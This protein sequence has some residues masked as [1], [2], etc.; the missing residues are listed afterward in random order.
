MFLAALIAASSVTLNLPNDARVRGTEL[1]LAAV[2]QVTSDDPELVERARNYALG[3]APAPGYSRLLMAEHLERELE[4]FLGVDVVVKGQP[5]CRVYP[6]IERVP[7]ATIEAAARRELE[8]TLL[9]KDAKATLL[10]SAAGIDV[11]AGEAPATFLARVNADSLRSG[12]FSVP[13]EVRVDGNAYRTVWTNWRLDLWEQ[14]SVLV[15]P[16][17]AGELITSDMLAEKRVAL[18]TSN[19]KRLDPRQIVGS[20][21]S[22]NL[23]TET[24]IVEADLIRPAIVRK[25]DALF[26]S[27]KK[28][29]INARVA[30]TAQENGAIGDRIRIELTDNKRVLTAVVLSRDTAEIDLA[31]KP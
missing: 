23:T 8:N 5:S 2:A 7:G 15:R 26:L 19:A 30:G 22:R 29:A 9:G 20:V 27:I 16:V 11:P 12:S 10:E 14:R 13:V 24:A 28:G 21:A 17:K 6:E 3:Y 31:P 4:R 18:D 1:T 25:G